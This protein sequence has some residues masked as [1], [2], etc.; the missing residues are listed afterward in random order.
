MKIMNL[1]KTQEAELEQRFKRLSKERRII[2]KRNLLT[3]L[4]R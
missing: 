3:A 4:W 2:N 1:T